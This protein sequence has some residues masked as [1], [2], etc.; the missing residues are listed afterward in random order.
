MI[1][2]KEDGLT[3]NAA[4]D[5]DFWKVPVDK[6]EVPVVV[7]FDRPFFLFVEDEITRRDLFVAKVFNPKTE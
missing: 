4:K 7:K 3:K 5:K 1:E 6:K 2:V